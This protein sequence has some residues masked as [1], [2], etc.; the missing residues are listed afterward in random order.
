MVSPWLIFIPLL[1][2]FS[3][4]SSGPISVC[5][6]YAPCKFPDGTDLSLENEM[7]TYKKKE[8]YLYMRKFLQSSPTFKHFWNLSIKT[9]RSGAQTQ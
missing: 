6:I 3:P 7:P 5:N 1:I 8:I 2:S 9:P 4:F